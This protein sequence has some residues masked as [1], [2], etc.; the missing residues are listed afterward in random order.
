MPALENLLAQLLSTE[1]T[2][3]V[4]SRVHR[5]WR[6]KVLCVITHGLPFMLGDLAHM[7][8]GGRKIHDILGIKSFDSLRGVIRVSA[9]RHPDVYL[10][11]FLLPDVAHNSSYV[12]AWNHGF[13]SQ[14]FPDFST[15]EFE[16][17]NRQRV[18]NACNQWGVTNSFS[19]NRETRMS[20]RA[21]EIAYPLTRPQRFLTVL[22][23]HGFQNNLFTSSETRPERTHVPAHRIFYYDADALAQLSGDSTPIDPSTVAGNLD[24]LT[25][26][27]EKE[28]SVQSQLTDRIQTQESQ[29]ADL[30]K[31]IEDDRVD[32]N[33]SLDIACMLENK[34]GELKE[35]IASDEK[36]DDLVSAIDGL[37]DA[38]RTILLEKLNT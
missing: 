38:A 12:Y 13:L 14:V 20:V 17:R 19:V 30:Q 24:E 15:D 22:L 25:A 10:H 21:R 1:P 27:L 11:R 34:I 32:L 5:D 2:D 29:I 28:L 8:V 9:D 35:Q 4:S 33:A 23:A 7:R 31:S 6:M 16:K 26:A 36:I 3:G 18:I 37:S